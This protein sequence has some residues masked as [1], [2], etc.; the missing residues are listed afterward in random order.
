MHRF[1]LHLLQN[2]LCKPLWS[3]PPINMV[4]ESFVRFLIVCSQQDYPSVGFLREK[5]KES[6]IVPILA[7]TSGVKTIFEVHTLCFV[8]NFV[9]LYFSWSDVI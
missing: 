7:V 6:K 4:R 9:N 8:L 5:L 1:S 3:M 2:M